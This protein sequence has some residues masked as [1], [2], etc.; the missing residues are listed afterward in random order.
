MD[1][2]AGSS[3]NVQTWLQEASS[4]TTAGTSRLDI[5]SLFYASVLQLFKTLVRKVKTRPGA[6]APDRIA[7][8]TQ[9]LTRF[10]LWGDGLSVL[11]GQLD[12]VLEDSPEL[13]SNVLSLLFHLSLALLAEITQL[14]LLSGSESG[15]DASGTVTSVKLMQ[16]R[17]A[18][19]L[20]ETDASP[21]FLCDLDSLSDSS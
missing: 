7:R 6:Q 14:T 5:T 4:T 11:Q 8:Y 15:E 20:R 2:Q 12:E 21:E 18:Q 19:F 3:R 17:V 9:E 13:R 10:Y 16:E 1:T